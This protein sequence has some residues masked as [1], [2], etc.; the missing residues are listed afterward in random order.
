[1]WIK[2]STIALAATV[3]L[4]SGVANAQARRPGGMVGG[5][6]NPGRPPNVAIGNRPAF[7]GIGGARPAVSGS[8][9]GSFVGSRP[10]VGQ[11]FGDSLGVVNRPRIGNTNVVN[12][13]VTVN[14]PVNVNRQQVNVNRPGGVLR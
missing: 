9:P 2:P 6:G 10:A 14:Q 12:R 11:Q 5:R 13:P 4:A 7:G 3:A 1:M 8:R